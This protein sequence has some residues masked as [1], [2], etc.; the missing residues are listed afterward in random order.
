MISCGRAPAA[1]KGGTRA[2]LSQFGYHSDDGCIY[3]R[4]GTGE[5]WGMRFG[6]GDVVGCGLDCA[7]EIIFYTLN[8]R[9]LGVAHDRVPATAYFPVVGV[10]SADTAEVNL[11]GPWKFDLSRYAEQRR[12][13]ADSWWASPQAERGTE[14]QAPLP[15]RVRRGAAAGGGGGGEAAALGLRRPPA[16]PTQ[17]QHQHLMQGYWVLHKLDDWGEAERAALLALPNGARRNQPKHW[18]TGIPAVELMLLQTEASMGHQPLDWDQ[19]DLGSDDTDSTDSESVDFASLS[20]E[21]DGSDG[22][23]GSSSDS[24]DDEAGGHLAAL[25]QVEEPFDWGSEDVLAASDGGEA[26]TEG[27]GQA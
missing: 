24:G 6:D 8:G 2:R 11:R 4:S 23:M 20:D 13:A 26:S 10:D 19:V 9:F 15:R 5:R 25:F 27:G 7:L 3:Q 21:E 14:R 1:L 12:A 17:A 18:R 16:L 22:L